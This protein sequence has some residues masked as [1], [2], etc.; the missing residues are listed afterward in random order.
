MSN[1]FGPKQNNDPEKG[2]SVSTKI[3]QFRNKEGFEPS[4]LQINGWDEMFSMRINPALPPE[5]QTK[6]QIFD[7]DRFVAT[8]LNMEKAMLLLYKIKKDILPAIRDQ[9]EKNIGI[10]VGG[11]GLITVGTGK[12]LTGSI[13]PYLAIHKSINPE[14]KKAEQSI[15]FEF[16]KTMTIDDYNP[17]TGTYTLEEGYHA[18]FL[19]FC[20][21][22]QSFIRTSNFNYHVNKCGSKYATDKALNTLS[23]IATKVGVDSD[24]T[25]FDSFD[26]QV[27][28]FDT[29]VANDL[30]KY[31]GNYSGDVPSMKEIRDLSELTN[32]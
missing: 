31:S 26:R 17:E 8:S 9:E 21:L 6:D 28:G 19:L 4:T 23:Y 15:Y 1:M 30:P 22:L 16:K 29:I 25:Q 12:V 2:K 27:S 3:Y 14:T 13:R 32:A 5:K 24:H 10:S 18:E 7:Y 11:D 20:E